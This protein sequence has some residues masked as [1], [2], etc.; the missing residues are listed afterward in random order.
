MTTLCA[1]EGNK[2]SVWGE[3]GQCLPRD[4][5]QRLKKVYDIVQD[6]IAYRI[7]YRQE[8]LLGPALCPYVFTYD[9]S[10][11]G[12]FLDTT[13]IYGLSRKELEEIQARPLRHFDGR[14]IVREVESEISHLDQ[15]SIVVTDQD[16]Q[17][18]VLRPQIKSLRYSDS[19]YLV[20]RHGDEIYLTFDGF[21]QMKGSINFRI[22][23]KGYYMPLR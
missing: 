3:T 1:S 7:F 16:G 19:N 22:E 13:I 12:W 6:R 11:G 4:L 20:L 15:I 17:S 2:V 9:A 5:S 23:A 21:E 8:V 10:R 14:L 18:H